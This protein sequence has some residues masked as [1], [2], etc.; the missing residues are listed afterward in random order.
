MNIVLKPLPSGGSSINSVY[1]SNSMLTMFLLAHCSSCSLSTV[2]HFIRVGTLAQRKIITLVNGGGGG[3]IPL[4]LSF[5]GSSKDAIRIFPE[6]PAAHSNVD[7]VGSLWGILQASLKDTKDCLFNYK[8]DSL[9]YFLTCTT[10]SATTQSGLQ[11]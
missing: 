8:S 10:G 3:G 2:P 5:F 11:L 9:F 6:G 4:Q 1:S 7:I